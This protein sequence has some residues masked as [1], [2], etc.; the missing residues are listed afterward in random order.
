MVWW[1]CVFFLST[2]SLSQAVLMNY[3]VLHQLYLPFIIGSDITTSEVLRRKKQRA[4]EQEELPEFS[5][6]ILFH[7]IV[8]IGSPCFANQT[9]GQIIWVISSYFRFSNNVAAAV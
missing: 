4:E 6:S 1:I 7:L 3:R 8:K 2:F 9:E 5:L